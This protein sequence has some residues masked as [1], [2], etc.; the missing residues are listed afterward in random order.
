VNQDIEIA[1]K[2]WVPVKRQRM[3]ADDHELNAV[4]A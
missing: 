3:G 1:R 4:R 2:A